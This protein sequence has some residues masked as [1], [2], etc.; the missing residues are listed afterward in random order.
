MTIA[1][2]NPPASTR[3]QTTERAICKPPRILLAEDDDEMRAL[4]ACVLRTDGYQVTEVRDGGRLLVQIASAYRAQ[5][6]DAACDVFVSDIRMPVCSGVEILEGLRRAHWTTPVILMTAFGNSATRR[7]AEALGA[8]VF[9]KPFD[10]DALRAAV[11]NALPGDGV[12][13]TTQLARSSHG[14]GRDNVEASMAQTHHV[15]D[16]LAPALE[17]G[18]VVDSLTRRRWSSEAFIALEAQIH[19]L[20]SAAAGVHRAHERAFHN[21]C[22]ASFRLIRDALHDLNVIIADKDIAPW[23]DGSSP[24]R[25]YLS[26]AYVWCGDVLHSLNELA[27]REHTLPWRAAKRE[28]A[29]SAADY[30]TEFLDP[31]FRALNELCGSSWAGHALQRVRP[32]IERIQSEVVSLSWALAP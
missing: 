3:W 5:G 24:L 27:G 4:V 29:D 32:P 8:I 10:L 19:L 7:R 26:A 31:L 28:A 12:G 17:Y 23:L 15:E 21:E 16:A 30:I 9:D 14:H 13:R 18:A 6:R 11:R 1:L 20:Q 2:S 22:L 25:G